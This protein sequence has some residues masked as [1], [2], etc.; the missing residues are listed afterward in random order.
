MAQKIRHLYA[1]IPSF[2][3]TARQCSMLNTTNERNFNQN[4][5]PS[6]HQDFS[7]LHSVTLQR[8]VLFI[9]KVNC[10]QLQSTKE[11]INIVIKKK[12]A[13]KRFGLLCHYIVACRHVAK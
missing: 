1:A 7:E 8:T 11:E 4:N 3:Q 6:K 10:E 13:E 2:T 5:A 12:R 9:Q